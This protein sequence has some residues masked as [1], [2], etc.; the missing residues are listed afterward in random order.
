MY[1]HF[2]RPESVCGRDDVVGCSNSTSSSIVASSDIF[3]L[4]LF[5]FFSTKSTR[6]SRKKNE[7]YLGFLFKWIFFRQTKR[8]KKKRENE[9]KQTN[10][11][12]KNRI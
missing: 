12:K 3:F 10:K 5:S 2:K 9:N 11:Q 1:D 7:L 4:F 8:T 6:K